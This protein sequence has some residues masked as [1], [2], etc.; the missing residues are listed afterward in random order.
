MF[1]I[2]ITI[3]IIIIIIHIITWFILC[4]FL[5]MI[6]RRFFLLDVIQV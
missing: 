1:I 6:S 3:I 5:S 2:D 4:N